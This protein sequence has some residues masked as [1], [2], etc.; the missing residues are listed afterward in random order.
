MI[1]ISIIIAL[2]VLIIGS[3][4]DIKKREVH[5]FVSYGLIF[6]A[7]GAALLYSIIYWD[8]TVLAQTAM[9]FIIGVI[10]AYGMF[11]LGQ[12]GGGDSKLIMGLGAVLGF[13]VFAIF[14]AKDY[15]LLIMLVNIVFV[16]A[17]YGLIWSIY[18][19]IKHKKAFMKNLRLWTVFR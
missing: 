16:G 2:I 19:A 8:Y 4:T 13:N 6:A 5:D 1:W 12:W 11:Y 9:G 14:G 18:L 7:F 3:I 17:I 10:I 15:W